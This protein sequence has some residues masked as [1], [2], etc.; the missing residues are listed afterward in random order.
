MNEYKSPKELPPEAQGALFD[1][2][3]VLADSKHLLGLRYGEWLSAP[4]LEASIAA[5]SMAQDE[6]GHA[7]LLYGLLESFHQ[8]LNLP[9][10]TEEPSQYRNL[11]LLD[12]AFADWTDFVVANTVLDTAMTVQLEAFKESSYLPLRQRVAKML[13]EERF[14]FQHGKGW[15][16][17]LVSAPKAKAE[18]EHRLRIVWP[19]VSAWLGK[20]SSRSEQAL[21]GFGIQDTDSDGLRT[22]FVERLG[23]LFQQANL[24]VPMIAWD[25]ITGQ[26][27]LTTPPDWTGWD[28]SFRR[29]SRTGPDRETFAQI[30]ALY[31]HS[32]PV[33]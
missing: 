18:L 20:P 27:V 28:E 10:R 3:L 32:Y 17:R 24:S 29:F 25:A 15:V 6:F 16:L 19:T 9:R 21:T 2:L 5:V 23:P 11:E 12:R 1:L 7:R 33:E 26:S 8:E 4:A 30:E 31:A 22:R 14:H 13:Q